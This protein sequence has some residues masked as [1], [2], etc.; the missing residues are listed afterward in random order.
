MSRIGLCVLTVSVGLA[1]GCSS[2]QRSVA[3][4]VLPVDQE[5]ELGSQMAAQLEQELTLVRDP[6]VVNYIQQL[7]ARITAAAAEDTP[8]GIEFRFHVVD[9]DATVNAFAIPGGDIYVYTGL[10][11]LAE[12]E[13]ELMGV[14]GH[15]VAH[16]T[17]R[18]IA[19]QLTAQYGLQA[20]TGAIGMAGGVTGL[21]GQLASSVGSQ[22]FLLKYSRDHERESDYFGAIYEATAGWDPHGMSRFFAKMDAMDSR[23]N[24]PTFLLTHPDPE[25][26]VENVE[27]H[28]AEMGQVPTETGRERYAQLLQRL[29]GPA[30]AK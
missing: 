9:D 8:E 25:E 3:N 17:R 5:K 14:L 26:R 16:V 20:L 12:D 2:V 18:H 22:G 7:G 19:Q 1:S 10:L 6:A 13:A 23:G 15:E 27:K 29:G 30:G 24:T 4:A 28:I 21:I 11:K